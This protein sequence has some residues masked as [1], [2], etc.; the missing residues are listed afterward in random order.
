[1]RIDFEVKENEV[2]FGQDQRGGRDIL[3][4]TRATTLEA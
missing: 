3:A 1:M 4:R 2:N